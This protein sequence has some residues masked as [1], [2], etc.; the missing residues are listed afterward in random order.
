MSA[1]QSLRRGF[2][3]LSTQ[4]NSLKIALDNEKYFLDLLKKFINEKLSAS[5]NL[6]S[7][8]KRD[9]ED[10]G[11]VLERI[12]HLDE[13]LGEVLIKFLDEYTGYR[14]ILKSIQ[15]DEDELNALRKKRNDAD[16]K[17]RSL[18]KSGKL[19]AVAVEVEL[20]NLEK[21]VLQLEADNYSEKRK[22]LQN[23][24]NMQFDAWIN[25][26]ANIAIIATFS[27]CLLAQIPQGEL[28]PGQDIPVY[29]SKKLSLCDCLMLLTNYKGEEVTTKIYGD[30][31]SSLRKYSVDSVK[32]G[33]VSGFMASISSNISNDYLTSP[34][35]DAIPH[36]PKTASPEK[37]PL[38]SPFQTSPSKN[39]QF[40][41]NGF[42]NTHPSLDNAINSHIMINNNN[43]YYQPNVNSELQRHPSGSGSHNQVQQRV[44]ETADQ[45]FHS[46]SHQQFLS[47]PPQQ[48]SQ[49][50]HPHSFQNQQPHPDR[51]LS[52][53]PTTFNPNSNYVNRASV[54]SSLP[55]TPTYASRGFNTP[56]IVSNP[57][58]GGGDFGTGSQSSD[59]GTS[60]GTFYQPPNFQ[61]DYQ[62]YQNYQKPTKPRI[63]T[64]LPPTDYMSSVPRS[65]PPPDPS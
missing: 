33:S 26:C 15:K 46:P 10:I 52:M 56:T 20:R 7:W 53:E 32:S 18:Q 42:T 50:F 36:A 47:P 39:F 54:Y 28:S 19:M 4:N 49:S 11:D 1:Y 45:H 16:D 29:D 6:A 55:S 13:K 24:L 25:L 43:S 2:R 12:H 63:R 35:Q 21:E 62:G 58:D 30:C 61:T 22:Q 57:M 41:Q 48:Q 8:G 17:F 9:S 31:C 51:R 64:K 59:G 27:K 65:S 23:A 5:E 60:M 38:S 44:F 14:K 3:N 37:A 40:P 34:S